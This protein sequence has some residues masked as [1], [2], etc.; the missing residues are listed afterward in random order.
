MIGLYREDA[1]G[2][3]MTR[4]SERVIVMLVLAW[5]F[6]YPWYGGSVVGPFRN[7]ADCNLIRQQIVTHTTTCWFTP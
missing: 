5:W 2:H 4:R 6:F 3:G 1:G 7:V